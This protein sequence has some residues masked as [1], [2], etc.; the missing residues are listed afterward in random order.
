M[1]VPSVCAFTEMQVRFVFLCLPLATALWLPQ[2]RLGSFCHPA[3][4]PAET[5][6]S[7]AIKTISTQQGS[8]GEVWTVLSECSRQPWSVGGAP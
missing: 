2:P 6:P 7:A 4:P 1:S 5:Q 8:R 3:A